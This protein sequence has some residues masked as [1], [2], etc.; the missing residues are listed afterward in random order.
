MQRQADTSGS[1]DDTF[2]AWFT[3]RRSGAALKL[4]SSG[5]TLGKVSNALRNMSEKGSYEMDG[6]ESWARTP[7]T[8]QLNV[9]RR[10]RGAIPGF[11]DADFTEMEGASSLKADSNSVHHENWDTSPL[12]EVLRISDSGSRELEVH[13]FASG[14]ALRVPFT[15]P[16]A[17]ATRESEVK[18]Y[19]LTFPGSKDDCL[20]YLEKAHPDIRSE[21]QTLFGQGQASFSQGE[22]VDIDALEAEVSMRERLT[23][24]L[25]FEAKQAM[26]VFMDDDGEGP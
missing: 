9:R 6:V 5:Q 4:R 7:G 3:D 8:H 15:R 25:A 24:Q 23:Q 26:K 22:P 2:V 21:L 18:H 10:A 19:R 20:S 1:A 13:S 16:F 14:S 12:L 17:I 11:D